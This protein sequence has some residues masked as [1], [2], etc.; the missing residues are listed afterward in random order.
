M[1]GTKIKDGEVVA[2]AGKGSP[3][4]GKVGDNGVGGKEMRQTIKVGVDMEDGQVLVWNV[5]K[6]V[7][8]VWDEEGFREL[9]E[10][11]ERQLRHENLKNYL[12]V[13]V[14]VKERASKAIQGPKMSGLIDPLGMNT[15]FRLR[16]RAR[17]GWHQ[18]WKTP[19]NEL[20]AALAGPYRQVRKQKESGAKTVYGEVVLEKE[21]AGYENGEVLKLMDENAK[22]ELV[23]V[24]CPEELF[25]GHLGWM[26]EKSRQMYDGNK[27]RFR[28]NVETLNVKLERGKRMTVIDDGD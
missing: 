23:A 27:S 9:P 2:K 8:L 16:I 24:E 25:Q 14:K 10:S 19:G 26:A 3:I 22:V 1:A 4:E 17:R 18:C 7:V 28:E 21:D 11:V 6:D 13:Q 5:D 15:E 12:V 20:D